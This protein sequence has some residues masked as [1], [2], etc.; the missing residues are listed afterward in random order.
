M[1][2]IHPRFHTPRMYITITPPFDLRATLRQAQH[3]LHKLIIVDLNP[4]IAV[5]IETFE[6]LGDLLDD[7]TRPHEPVERDTRERPRRVR[8]GRRVL[9][10]D[11][12]DEAR[13]ETI[14]GGSERSVASRAEEERCTMHAPKL[15]ERIPEFTRVDRPRMIPIEMSKEVLPVLGTTFD[16]FR[17]SSIG[18]AYLDVPPNP[19]KLREGRASSP[20]ARPQ[21]K[22]IRRAC[23]NPMVPLRSVS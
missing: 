13:R 5:G 23:L 11:E 4:P 12:L 7:D 22:V 16:F 19:R 15:S 14:P 3:D 18:M 20:S 21:E 1:H 6:R 2:H 9:A 10:L 8:H 17:S